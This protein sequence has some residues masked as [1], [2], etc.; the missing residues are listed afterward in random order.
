MNVVFII[1]L[2]FTSLLEVFILYVI[3]FWCALKLFSGRKIIKGEM[4][5]VII[6]GLSILISFFSL[7]ILFFTL[8]GLF[9]GNGVC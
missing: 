4:L 7:P 5:K 6:L 2:I 8:S 9:F 1:S 3:L